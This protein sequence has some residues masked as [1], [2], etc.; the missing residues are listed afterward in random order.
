MLLVTALLSLSACAETVY[1]TNL[2]IYCPPIVAYDSAFN[3]R[4]AQEIEALPSGST[5]IEQ[6][7]TDYAAMRDR[8]RACQKEQKNYGN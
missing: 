3:E 7:I 4:L 8:A 1:R 6:T 2:E 5:A